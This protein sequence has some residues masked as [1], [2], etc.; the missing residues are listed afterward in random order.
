VPDEIKPV[1]LG[2]RP[3]RHHRQLRS[4][5]VPRFQNIPT[6]KNM[7]LAFSA[8]VA[9][10]IPNKKARSFSLRAFESNLV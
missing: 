10:S 7:G 4:S 5:G 8:T 2:H 3:R 6:V 1:I 9:A